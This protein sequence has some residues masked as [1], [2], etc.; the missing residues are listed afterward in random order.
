MRRAKSFAAG[1]LLIG[2]SARVVPQEPDQALE[3]SAG[4]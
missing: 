2:L 1:I 3:P 4:R